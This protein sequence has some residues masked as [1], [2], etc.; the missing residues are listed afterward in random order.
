M[1]TAAPMEIVVNELVSNALKYAFPAGE[2]GEGEDGERENGE[3]EDGE[4]E[5]GEGKDGEREN[6]EK[7]DGER[8]DEEIHISL[9]AS[10]YSN[11]EN[12]ARS[13][14]KRRRLSVYF[15]F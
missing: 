3:G 5:N 10:E 8:E 1:D 7:E 14:Q 13:L 4:R 11:R 2:K 12:E 15:L 9:F 6:G